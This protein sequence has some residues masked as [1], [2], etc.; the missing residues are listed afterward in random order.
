ME[1]VDLELKRDTVLIKL[2][3]KLDGC[4]EVKNQIE[5]LFRQRLLSL[6]EI[7]DEHNKI[8]GDIEKIKKFPTLVRSIYHLNTRKLAFSC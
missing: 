5:V 6:E 1:K 3:D 7:F 2:L 8:Y 4:Q